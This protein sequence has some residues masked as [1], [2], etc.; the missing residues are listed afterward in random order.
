MRP[1]GTRY[2]SHQGRRKRRVPAGRATGPAFSTVTL[3]SLSN[4]LL[5]EGEKLTIEITKTG[6]GVSLPILSGQIEY[7]VN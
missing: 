2:L 4:T 5:A 7:T 3:G 6:L 1:A